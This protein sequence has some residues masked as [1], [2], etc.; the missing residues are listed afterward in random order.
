MVYLGE[1][2]LY[3]RDILALRK[4]IREIQDKCVQLFWD[5]VE[6]PFAEIF[7]NICG[8]SQKQLMVITKSVLENNQLTITK[9]D[10]LNKIIHEAYY[11]PW[12]YFDEYL[13][14]EDV[15]KLSDNEL[16]QYHKSC[17]PDLQDFY[18][19]LH[20]LELGGSAFEIKNKVN[21]LLHENVC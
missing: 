11:S 18:Q 15:V 5:N 12:L 20:I 21:T 6:D 9:I 4:V 3:R 19:I 14:A 8:W 7:E 1:V 10:N 2:M 13:D 16:G 17:V